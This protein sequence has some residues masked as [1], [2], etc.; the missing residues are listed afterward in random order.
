MFSKYAW[1]VLLKEKRGISFVN[2]FQKLIS[3]HGLNSVV[4]FTISLLKDF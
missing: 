4:N 2:A 3:K 1:V